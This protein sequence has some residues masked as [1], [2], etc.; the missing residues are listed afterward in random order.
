MAHNRVVTKDIQTDIQIDAQTIATAV[1][2]QIGIIQGAEII[3]RK[4]TREITRAKSNVRSALTAN[5]N[6]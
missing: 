4:R 1:I 6:L 3:L 2:D 5:V